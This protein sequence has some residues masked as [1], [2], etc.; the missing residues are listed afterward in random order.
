MGIYVVVFTEILMYV[1]LPV[2]LNNYPI[3]A[4]RQPDLK[5]KPVGISAGQVQ[6]QRQIDI[7]F[8]TTRIDLLA[9]AY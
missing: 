1:H 4:V 9:T 8:I 6:C 7:P 5:I 2:M 3:L